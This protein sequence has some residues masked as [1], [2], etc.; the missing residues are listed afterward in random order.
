ML[1]IGEDNDTYTCGSSNFIESLSVCVKNP[2]FGQILKN[3]SICRFLYNFL[4]NPQLFG[5]QFLDTFQFGYFL[6]LLK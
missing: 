5:L 3:I 6:I 2:T 4:L 1:A